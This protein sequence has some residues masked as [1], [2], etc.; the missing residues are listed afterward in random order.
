MFCLL[1][2]V[3]KFAM[4]QFDS[5]NLATNIAFEQNGFKAIATFFQYLCQFFFMDF[6]STYGNLDLGPSELKNSI[7][8]LFYTHPNK[9]ISF[10]RIEENSNHTGKHQVFLKLCRICLK[11]SVALYFHKSIY[12]YT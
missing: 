5:P 4:F 6:Y 1:L 12:A 7:V 10:K 9:Y 11:L 8:A 2:C 3:G